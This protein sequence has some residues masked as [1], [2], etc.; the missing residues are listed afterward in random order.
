MEYLWQQYD[1]NNKYIIAQNLLSPYSEVQG[2][3]DGCIEVNPLFRFEKIF[4][5]LFSNNDS[6]LDINLKKEIE[7]ILIHYLTDLDFYYGMHKF[8]LEEEQIE[9]EIE[10]NFYGEEIKKIYTNLGKKEQMTILSLLNYKNKINNKKSL[11]CEAIS[12]IF[13][14]AILYFYKEKR[15]F[16]LYI[17]ENNTKENIDK[18]ILI[19]DLFLDNICNLEVFWNKHFG[20]IGENN[21]MS[22]D[23]MIVY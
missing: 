14:K 10:K 13:P 8:V 17:A 11:F 7:N 15:K 19:E 9:Q 4:R 20:I 16:L 23:K 3:V 5:S 22:I 1:K 6:V 12:K 2:M 21:T 18:M